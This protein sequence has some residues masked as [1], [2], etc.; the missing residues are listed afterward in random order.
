MITNYNKYLNK[1]KILE[2]L[3]T[4]PL[5]LSKR[6]RDLLEQIDHEIST[7][8]LSMHSDLDTRVKKTFVD[9]HNERPDYITFIQPNK[10]VQL[11]G[12][13]ITEDE[14]LIQL[15]DT[16]F[17]G[18]D[19]D[20]EIY[21]RYRSEYKLGRL[22][23]EIFGE[24]YPN[25]I[26]GGQ[27]KKDI[28]SFV[29]MYKALFLQDEKFS[30]FE[31]VSGN[32]ISHWY[33]RTNYK[34]GEGSLGGS[35][36]QSVPSEYFDIYTKNPDKVNM[37]IFYS[38]D[39]KTK[40]KGRAIIWHLDEPSDRVFMDRVYVN[41]YS[42]EQIFINYAKI[43]GWFY[44]SSQSMG[45]DVDLIDSRN[46]IRDNYKVMVQLNDI[47]YE[48]F[49]YCDTMVYF[50]KRTK[51]ISNTDYYGGNYQLTSTSGDYYC[52]NED[53]DTVWSNYHND[54]IN[55]SS[56]VY[57]QLGEDWVRRD[58]AIRVYNTG[59]G[60]RVYSVPNNP[61]IVLQ[62]FEYG[63]KRMKKYFL[64]RRCIWSD[65]LSTWI[66]E[67]SV[68]NVWLDKEKTKSGIEHKKR[69]NIEY[70]VIDGENY[71]ADLV[72]TETKQLL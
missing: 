3:K 47:E 13:D 9:I 1:L 71:S 14:Q 33:K 72:D 59:L 37:L 48:Y 28:E 45:S 16:T 29:N 31:L 70:Y 7:E 21:K 10:V 4:F 6:L 44:K 52:D 69:E 24:K 40:I 64:K 35:C 61:D 27:N 42:D 55:R 36:M 54:E 68:R 23:T 12:L 43:N 26:L 38:D 11:L 53:E 2:S 18:I 51:K 41:N 32:D 19:D 58:D 39:S 50:S 25:S 62:E 5:Y 57:C 63:D 22:I 60:E 46:D 30:L 17:D 34:N 49:P 65:Y 15:N 66:F 56:A 20:N 8:L 67:D